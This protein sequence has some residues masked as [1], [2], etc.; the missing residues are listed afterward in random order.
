MLRTYVT[1]QKI[2][3]NKHVERVFPVAKNG[4]EAW[5]VC[6]FWT[7]KAIVLN[8]VSRSGPFYV[9]KANLRHVW[10]LIWVLRVFVRVS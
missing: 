4:F 9:S 2:N 7:S 6:C 5:I 3:Q 8:L 1:T 10:S